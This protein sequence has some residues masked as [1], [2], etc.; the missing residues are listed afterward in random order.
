VARGNEHNDLNKKRTSGATVFK[1]SDWASFF[2]RKYGQGQA[3]HNDQQQI[4]NAYNNSKRMH[5]T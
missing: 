3:T 4:K 5:E 2:I 1:I